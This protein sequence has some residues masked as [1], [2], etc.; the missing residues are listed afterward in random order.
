MASAAATPLATNLQF[1]PLSRLRRGG[2]GGG[3]ASD[4]RAL[5]AFI[6][7]AGAGHARISIYGRIKI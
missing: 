1:W 4:T 2:G 3:G 7:S 6:D 5:P